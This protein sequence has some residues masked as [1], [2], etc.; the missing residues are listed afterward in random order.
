MLIKSNLKVQ[1]VIIARIYA[2][3][4]T[5]WNTVTS[6]CDYSW[7]SDITSVEIS[8]ER[9]FK[10]ISSDGFFTE[11]KITE[12]EPYRRY[13]FDLEN[14]N[15]CGSWTGYFRETEDETDIKFVETVTVRKWWLYPF[16]KWYL[17]RQQKRY[18][19]DLKR[20]CEQNG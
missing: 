5:V 2:D 8:D 7:R 20:K 12:C 17:R 19:E 15:L 14:K 3:L 4:H 6:L 18:V 16:V 10:E 13:S 1:S 11:F 9:C